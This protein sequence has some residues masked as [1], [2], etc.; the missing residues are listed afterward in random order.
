MYEKINIKTL[1]S[2]ESIVQRYI[3]EI[4][5]SAQNRVK[6]SHGSSATKLKFKLPKALLEKN[7]GGVAER[8]PKLAL[9]KPSSSNFDSTKKTSWIALD[10]LSPACSNIASTIHIN[11]ITFLMYNTT[12]LINIQFCVIC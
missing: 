11:K 2:V 5:K 9:R 12:F 8:S 7:I 6:I 4:N 10:G 1:Y 3:T